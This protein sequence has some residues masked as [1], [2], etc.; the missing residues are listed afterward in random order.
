MRCMSTRSHV[1][2]HFGYRTCTY[3]SILSALVQY[4]GTIPLVEK[5]FWNPVHHVRHVGHVGPVGTP[6]CDLLD[7]TL[8]RRYL[9]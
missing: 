5:V 6:G 8:R 9:R 4:S 7:D 1:H 3:C 2:V